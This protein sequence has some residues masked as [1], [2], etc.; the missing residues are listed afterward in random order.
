MKFQKVLSQY[1]LLMD[2]MN[3]AIS[4]LLAR[5]SDPV[6]I[7]D[8]VEDFLIDAYVEGFAGTGYLLGTSESLS[9]PAHLFEVVRKEIDGKTF[10]ERVIEHMQEGNLD[11]VLLVANT[12]GHR[13][14]TT[15]AEDSARGAAKQGLSVS[16]SWVTMLDERVRDTH[17]YLQGETV[18]VDARFHTFDGD[19][20][21]RPGDF[22]RAENNIGCRGVV[23]YSIIN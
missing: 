2:E 20:A 14:Y 17:S 10:R 6:V 21:S 7:A 16:K 19:S 18:G 5:E 12:D 13:V 11:G 8:A 15:A 9:S 3:I 4:E 1:Q 23:E 22:E